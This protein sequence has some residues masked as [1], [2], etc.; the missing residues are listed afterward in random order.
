[1]LIR[2]FAQEIVIRRIQ[3][4]M[5]QNNRFLDYY[6]KSEGYGDGWAEYVD[7]DFYSTDY[8]DCHGDYY[9][10]EVAS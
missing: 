3:E 8:N 2:T 4:K 7:T 1:M 10:V 5:E 6:D 9:D